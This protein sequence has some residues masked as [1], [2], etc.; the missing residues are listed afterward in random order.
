LSRFGTRA[1]RMDQ[2]AGATRTVTGLRP[3]SRYTLMA[4]LRSLNGKSVMIGVKNYGGGDQLFAA[5]SAA[6]YNPQSLTFTTG[7]TTA[8]TIFVYQPPG[9]IGLADDFFF[10]VA[11]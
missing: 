1:L 11:P 3:Y 6:S 2:E 4:N 7:N 9:S 8:A 10:G 5:T